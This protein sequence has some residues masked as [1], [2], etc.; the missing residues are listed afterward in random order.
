MARA[1]KLGPRLSKLIARIARNVL[2]LRN[3][4]GWTQEQL[5]ERLDCDLRWYQRLESGSYSFNLDTLVRLAQAL[6]VDE[7]ELFDS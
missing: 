7:R 1:S 4:K 3:E 6:G 5:A 2:R